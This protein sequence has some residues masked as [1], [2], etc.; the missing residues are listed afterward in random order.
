MCLLRLQ[1]KSQGAS[2]AGNAQQSV[3]RPCPQL[4]VLCMLD[5]AVQSGTY[6]FLMPNILGWSGWR[7]GRQVFASTSWAVFAGQ[8]GTLLRCKVVE[9]RCFGARLLSSFL[10]T[11]VAE[12]DICLSWQS[13]G[14]MTCDRT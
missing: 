12:L 7:P 4:N 2:A 10:A 14:I 8:V 5:V 3:V 13:M 1:D 9:L 6:K 11:Q